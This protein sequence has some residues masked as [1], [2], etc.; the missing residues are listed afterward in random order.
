MTRALVLSTHSLGTKG[1]VPK[2]SLM[3]TKCAWHGA[4]GFLAPTAG[5]SPAGPHW[6]PS[7]AEEKAQSSEASHTRSCGGGGEGGARSPSP[8]DPGTFPSHVPRWPSLPG[9][10]I[11]HA[12]FN[13][14]RPLLWLSTSRGARSSARRGWLNSG[15][16]MSL[17]G[18]GLYRQNRPGKRPG[19]AGGTAGAQA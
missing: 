14:T 4:R 18:T 5:K 17:R 10:I 15:A 19:T 7:F 1:Q 6:D 11:C 13:P 2:M 9:M 3:G 16:E 8:R 12:L